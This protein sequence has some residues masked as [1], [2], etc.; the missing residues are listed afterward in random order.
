MEEDTNGK[1]Q[2]NLGIIGSPV[3]TLMTAEMV[4]A[5][6]AA[7]ITCMSWYRVLY[8]HTRVYIIAGMLAE[9]FVVDE[10]QEPFL[11]AGAPGWVLTQ[12]ILIAILANLSF[13]VL[14]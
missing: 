3:S 12:I 13:Y 1:S 11:S 9:I 2:R 8:V 4:C 5:A 6:A 10:D 14:F 7:A